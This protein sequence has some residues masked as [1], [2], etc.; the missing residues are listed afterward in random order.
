MTR[1]SA[2]SILLMSWIVLCLASENKSQLKPTDGGT[3]QAPASG[4]KED[5]SKWQTVLLSGKGIKFKLPSDWQL[6]GPDLVNKNEYFTLEERGWA[7]PNRGL[8]R[9]F[10]STFPKGFVSLQ[11]TIIPTKQALEEK[12]NSVM[13]TENG[14]R[15][16]SDVKKLKINRVEGVFRRLHLDFKDKDIG[17]RSGIVWTGYRIYRGKAQEV[18]IDISVQGKG[19]EL[20]RAI[21]D[22]LEIEQDKA[23]K[24]KP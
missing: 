14:D 6:E 17:E 5:L 10:I 12:F 8:I 4:P 1:K 13:R 3:L 19:E 15:A 21:F 9:F 23:V 11:R 24:R 22:T 16:F 20:L 18:D 7:S 2:I